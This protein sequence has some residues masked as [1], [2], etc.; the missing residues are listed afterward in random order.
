MNGGQSL[1]AGSAI[2]LLLLCT[3]DGDLHPV[4]V[5]TS[6]GSMAVTPKVQP[7]SS[8]NFVGG[9]V[10]DL[11]GNDPAADQQFEALFAAHDKKVIEKVTQAVNKETR[12]VVKK[13]HETMVQPKFTQLVQKNI[14]QDTEI[15]SL[16]NQAAKHE[17]LLNELRDKVGLM[18]K[19]SVSP[20]DRDFEEY[21]RRSF[22]HMLTIS[23][24]GGQTV[25]K[26]Y[27]LDGLREWLK[28]SG[29]TADPR[30]DGPA[31]GSR[32]TLRLECN[33]LLAATDLKKAKL[34][35]KTSTGWRKLSCP[36]ATKPLERITI[37]ANFD[38]GPRTRKESGGG[39]A[40]GKIIRKLVPEK[41]FMVRGSTVYLDNNALVRCFAPVQGEPSKIQIFP[42]NCLEAKLDTEAVKA[43]FEL[44]APTP[45]PESEWQCL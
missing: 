9:G 1:A 13:Y 26:N 18:S 20:A 23:S 2:L 6:S 15:E 24:E 14:F 35:L 40:L 43:Q 22:L 38:E 8:A 37:Y 42:T 32:F 36:S 28:D 16:K 7:N 4:P 5:Q 10:A 17:V 25:S 11:V 41:K 33:D 30:L 29:I 27:A 45:V 21:N 19:P 31:L 12:E 44:G 39:R 3:D 34:A